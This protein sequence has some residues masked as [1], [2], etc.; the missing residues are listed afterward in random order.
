MRLVTRA[1]IRARIARLEVL[2]AELAK[3]VD[4]LDFKARMSGGEDE[5]GRAER[6]GWRK[7]YDLFS[8]ELDSVDADLRKAHAALDAMISRLSERVLIASRAQSAALDALLDAECDAREAGEHELAAAID[9]A[10]KALVRVGLGAL[11]DS[12]VA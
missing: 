7:Q 1:E 3:D 4:E 11:H 8:R 9:T 6:A 5:A 2:R 10:R 12:I